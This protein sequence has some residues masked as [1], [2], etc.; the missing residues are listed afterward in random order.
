M[1][2]W[3]ILGVIVLSVAVA[4][5]LAP[6]DPMQT[7]TSATLQPPGATHWMGTDRLG[8]D[9]F[10]RLLYGGQ[11]TVAMAAGAT[12]I[13]VII[14]LVIG[15]IAGTAGGLIDR[16]IMGLID[17]LLAFPALL[18]ALVVVTL[19]G[20]GALSVSV[21]VGIALIAQY[22]RVTRSA[23]LAVRDMP[24]VEAARAL[25]ASRWRMATRHILRNAA[26]TLLA[27][28]GVTFSYS[29]L[30]SGALSFLGL[31]GDLGV[32][33][34]GAMLFDGRMTFRS[35]PWLSLA[36]GLAISSVVLAVNSVSD[37]VLR[38]GQM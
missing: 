1:R 6:H 29:L 26:P 33:D 13:A 27:F 2:A 38:A 20:Q 3:V 22:A 7:D 8:R 12:A 5:L 21:A 19:M 11:R 36:P 23:V 30:N 32:P 15:G 31:S 4:P 9:V 18:L 28:A 37:R 14:G 25:G 35:A 34:W 10:S 24:Y 17:A 16:A